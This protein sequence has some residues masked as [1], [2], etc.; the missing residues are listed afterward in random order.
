M[1]SINSI[2]KKYVTMVEL[3]VAL[4][5]IVLLAV[6]VRWMVIPVEVE[7]HEVTIS[8][9]DYEFAGKH[10]ESR[11]IVHTEC[12][13]VWAAKADRRFLYVQDGDVVIKVSVYMDGTTLLKSIEPQDNKGDK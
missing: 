9:I 3:L 10:G 11:M 6:M 5:V 12:G 8:N 2:G 4:A 7:R 13:K 1:N